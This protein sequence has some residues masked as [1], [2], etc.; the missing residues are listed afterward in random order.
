MKQEGRAVETGGVCLRN[1]DGVP[2]LPFSR[3]GV[4]PMDLA[5][6]HD[7]LAKKDELAPIDAD[8]AAIL[9]ATWAALEQLAPLLPPRLAPKERGR[10]GGIVG[11]GAPLRVRALCR[12]LATEPRLFAGEPIDERALDRCQARAGAFLH[13]STILLDLS[14][15]ARDA[16]L[17]EQ[18]AAA[19]ATAA[20][21]ARLRHQAADPDQPPSPALHRKALLLSEALVRRPGGRPRKRRQKSG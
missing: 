4:T 10:L 6:R 5:M 19:R 13:L 8:P 12:A 16:A 17:S 21:V 9:A 7:L 15:R 20:V 11:V 2:V 14:A 3:L 18:A 1:R